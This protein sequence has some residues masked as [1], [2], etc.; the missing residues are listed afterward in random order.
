VRAV[1]EPSARLD[2]AIEHASGVMSARGEVPD[3][4]R[5]PN[6]RRGITAG[7]VIAIVSSAVVAHGADRPLAVVLEVLLVSAA[8]MAVAVGILYAIS[9]RPRA[10]EPKTAA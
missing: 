8:F 2:P 10:S 9:R 3:T 6:Y 5:Y 1:P 4:M 7:S